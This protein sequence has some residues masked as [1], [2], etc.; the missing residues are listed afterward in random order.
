MQDLQV[1][2]GVE[3]AGDG[4]GE[5]P[6]PGAKPR[7]AWQER[8]FGMDFLEPFND[9]ERLGQDHPVAQFEGRHQPLRV[10]AE[11]SGRPLFAAAEMMNNVLD[12]QSFEVQ[13]DA[14]PEGCAAA[15]IAV[16]LQGLGSPDRS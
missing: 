4:L 7:L 8:R 11:V 16:K 1:L 14:N 2:K 3:V 13:R 5:R 9:R 10:E 12:S 6:D 15:K